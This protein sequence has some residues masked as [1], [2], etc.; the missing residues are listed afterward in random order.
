[1]TTEDDWRIGKLKDPFGKQV[2]P[3]KEGNKFEIA[4]NQKQR[5]A[6]TALA[7]V[8]VQQLTSSW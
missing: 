1:M 5:T 3:C 7:K 8:A 4:V 2:T 6:K